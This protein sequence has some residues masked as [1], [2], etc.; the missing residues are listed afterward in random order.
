MESTDPR[1]VEFDYDLPE[2]LIARHP[3]EHRDG[4]RLLLSKDGQWSPAHIPDLLAEFCDGDVL[5]VNDTRVLQARIYGRRATGGRVEILLM[6]GVENP[7]PAMV[8]PSRRLK[9]GEEIQLL[10]RSGEASEYTARIVDTLEDGQRVVALSADPM[11]VMVECGRVALPPYMRRDAELADEER[12]QTVFASNPGAIA[13]PTA[14]LHLTETM[15]TSLRERG[16]V[17][18]PITLH[19]G[20]GTF[21]NLRS[22]DLDRGRL[23]VER[24]FIPDETQKAIGEA[25]SL[26]SRVTAVGTTVTRCLESAADGLGGVHAGSGE[27]GLFI[28]EGFKFQVIQ[29]LLTNFHLPKTSLLMLVSAFGGREHVLAGYRQAIKNGFRFYSYGDA[30]FLEPAEWAR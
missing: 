11:T 29:R 6:N 2:E 27:T 15:L 23:H 3:P 7:V 28:Q 25:R 16:V 19:V 20:P 5:V 30:M 13:A 4:G 24:F 10:S 8:R 17:I 22:E 21:R 14:S 12:Y 18:V 9:H 1:I 26:G